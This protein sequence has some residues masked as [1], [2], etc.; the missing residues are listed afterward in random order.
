MI[1]RENLHFLME[2]KDIQIK[3]LSVKTGISENTI[4]TYLRS[5]SAEPKLSKA[6]LIAKAL[7]VSV[8]FLANGS[9]LSDENPVS[10]EVFTI[11]ESIKSFNPKELK[12]ISAVINALKE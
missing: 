6:V 9:E 2:S 4:K 7:G 11:Q 1:F 3:E 5:A 10:K 12:I 8:E